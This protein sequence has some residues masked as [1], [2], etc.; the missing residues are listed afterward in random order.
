MD[1]I[2]ISEE[3]AHAICDTEESHFFDK[4]SK[5]ISG[6]AVQK[7]VVAFSN[8]DGGELIIGVKDNKDEPD[9]LLRW[10]G[11]QDIE[12]MNGIMQAVFDLAPSPP[13]KYEI[14]VCNSFKGRVLRINI[15][16]SPQVHSSADNIVYQRHGAQSIKITDAQRITALGYA[17]GADSFEDRIVTDLPA[18]TIVES[19]EITSF[20]TNY[21]PKTDPL[22]FAVNQNLLDYKTWAPRVASIVL[23][24]DNPSTVIPTRC[25]VRIA[26]YET[27]D[28]DPERDSL[29]HQESIE[30]PCVPLIE[31]TVKAVMQIMQQVEVWTT[32]GLAHLQ[33][34]PEAI[35]ETIVNAIIH[36][37]YSISDD[38][39]VHIF[40]NRIEI[41]S[42]G[43]L[44][45]YVTV[46]NI[47]EA[48][49][50]RNPKIVRTLARY[51]NPPNKDLGEGLN[52]TFQK[53]KEWGLKNPEIFED[54]NYVKVILPH[55]RLA[56]PATAILRFLKNNNHITNRQARE[57]TGIKSENLVK[58][59]FYK[60]RDEGLIE[61]VPGLRGPSSAWQLT[62]TGRKKVEDDDFSVS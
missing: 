17:K 29:A 18:E 19:K 12:A 32:E 59:E 44:P 40:D 42:P 49:F 43:K 30:G 9:V 13:L 28:D 23:F 4:K 52:T 21:S 46:E 5:D 56:A 24:H 54:G 6:K 11:F 62:D 39:Q 26:R 45:G 33:Y 37:D 8:A 14:L 51:R 27:R 53:M 41:H 57:I 20:L 15:E 16:K 35:W 10:D 3:E 60:L 47:L 61:R 2:T 1:S 31:N 50:S 7:A 25:A 36:R 58:V 38:V 22:S 34:P 55:A 48:R